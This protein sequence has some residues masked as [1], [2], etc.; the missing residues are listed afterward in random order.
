MPLTEAY[1]WCDDK[2]YTHHWGLLHIGNLPY[3]I[4][5]IRN[6]DAILWQ[7]H[8]PSPPKPPKLTPKDRSTYTVCHFI[9]RAHTHC[10]KY[11]TAIPYCNQN[12]TIQKTFI[13]MHFA[14][15]PIVTHLQISWNYNFKYLTNIGK[16]INLCFLC[17]FYNKDD[18]RCKMS[19]ICSW[20]YNYRCFLTKVSNL[21]AM[22]SSKSDIVTPPM[23][24]FA[25]CQMNLWSSFDTIQRFKSSYKCLQACCHIAT[26]HSLSK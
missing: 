2:D 19:V 12:N 9:I 22:M 10:I 23:G 18:K 6:M 25:S 5:T 4:N 16:L 21:A 7:C 1:K 24:Y 14:N 11:W 13:Q 15:K 3:I 26:L 8:I 17:L 20:K